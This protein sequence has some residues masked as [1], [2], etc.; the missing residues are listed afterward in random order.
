MYICLTACKQ[1]EI[2]TINATSYIYVK[3]N[4]YIKFCDCVCVFVGA[5]HGTTGGRPLDGDDP[6][7]EE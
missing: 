6:S 4:M 2:Y 3:T 5:F 1:K 7:V